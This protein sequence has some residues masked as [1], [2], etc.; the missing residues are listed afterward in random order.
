MSV[1]GL[2]LNPYST[3]YLRQY[4]YIS[5]T[6]GDRKKTDFRFGISIE[7]YTMKKKKFLIPLLTHYCLKP[8]S[9]P[10]LRCSLR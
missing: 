3:A 2:T 1:F 10:I 8:F 9:R 6:R 4:F 7:K 5:K